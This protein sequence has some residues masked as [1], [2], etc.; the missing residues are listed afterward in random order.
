MN[1]PFFCGLGS[2]AVF[3]T[4]AICYL[5]APKCSSRVLKL[6]CMSFG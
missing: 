2:F 1:I 4:I 6:A 5:Q 3:G